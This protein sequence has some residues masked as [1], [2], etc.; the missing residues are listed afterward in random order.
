MARRFIFRCRYART[1]YCAIMVQACARRFIARKIMKTIREM[2]FAT[3]IQMFVRLSLCQRKFVANKSAALLIQKVFR[4]YNAHKEYEVL[5]QKV[6][7]EQEKNNGATVIQCMYRMS[8]ARQMF[9]EL[10]ASA[11]KAPELKGKALTAAIKADKAAA[12]YKQTAQDRRKELDNLTTSLEDAKISA[13]K[14]NTALKELEA[15]KAEL[16]AVRAELKLE[17]KLTAAEKKRAD[18][19][20]EENDNLYKK[21]KSGDFIVG[22]QY[23]RTFYS[24]HPDLEELDKQMFS[25]VNHSRKSKQDV[26]EILNL[27]SILK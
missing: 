20:Q 5:H 18:K 7:E 15:L 13:A 22:E 26:K 19:L 3:R 21:L 8:F 17:K 10:K 12:V 14:A 6:K 25:M 4:G 27:L 2:R 24:A 11:K 23:N 1:L 9:N 16:E